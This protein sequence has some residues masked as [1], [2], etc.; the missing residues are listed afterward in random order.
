M[1]VTK[2]RHRKERYSIL[3]SNAQPAWHQEAECSEGGEAAA[4][5]FRIVRRTGSAWGHIWDEDRAGQRTSFSRTVLR[6]RK[7]SD[8]HVALSQEAAHILLTPGPEPLLTPER[9]RLVRET[10]QAANAQ[11]RNAV[12]HKLVP[13]MTSEYES[14]IKAASSSRPVHLYMMLADARLKQA[15]PSLPD[16]DQRMEVLQRL[17]AEAEGRGL[18]KLNQ[19][20]FVLRRWKE[21]L[22]AD[23]RK[24]AFISDVV[25]DWI[26][27]QAESLFRAVERCYRTGSKA[28]VTAMLPY[29]PQ[30]WEK[31]VRM[32]RSAAEQ[33]MGE[34]A[35]S[36]GP[37]V[38]LWI[39]AEEAGAGVD[40]DERMADADIVWR[41]SFSPY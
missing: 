39:T 17:A 5:Y 11:E 24:S 26:D 40:E 30:A 32:V 37:L 4:T 3:K 29:H 19:Q 22:S 33:I 28:H 8:V 6:C 36:S 16:I 20:W 25:P 12:L 31:H 14:F 27:M 10:L 23:D 2:M 34:T 9:I 7:R 15:L 38:G 35:R 41:C 21:W 18:D 1:A 13:L